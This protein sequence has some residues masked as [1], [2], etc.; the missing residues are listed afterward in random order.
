[1]NYSAEEYALLPSELNSLLTFSDEWTEAER[2]FDSYRENYGLAAAIRCRAD[3]V[4]AEAKRNEL[5]QPIR[6]RVEMIINHWLS[7]ESIS[8]GVESLREYIST[9]RDNVEERLIE[10]DMSKAERDGL[11]Y[12]RKGATELLRE[13]RKIEA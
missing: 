1:M 4:T 8:E 10:Q 13:L 9:R 2:A 12:F 5:M 3:R 7:D 6:D 11:C